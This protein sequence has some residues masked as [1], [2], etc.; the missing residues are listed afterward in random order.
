M[1]HFPYSYW[2]TYIALNSFFLTTTLPNRCFSFLKMRELIFREMEDKPKNT[3]V[4]RKFGNK[5]K[6]SPEFRAY[7][8]FIR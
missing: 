4:L 1:K 6:S 8:S 5:P 2:F 3:L 7:R